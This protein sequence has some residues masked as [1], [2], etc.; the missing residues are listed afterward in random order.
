MIYIIGYYAAFIGIIILLTH[1]KRFFK[2][3]NLLEKIGFIIT[4]IGIIVPIVYG[5]IDGFLH[6]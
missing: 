4:S 5:F 2:K 3:L 1:A 6:H